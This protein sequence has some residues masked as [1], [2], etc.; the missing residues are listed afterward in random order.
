LPTPRDFGALA[1]TTS[2]HESQTSLPL[3]QLENRMKTVSPKRANGAPPPLANHSNQRHRL[4]TLSAFA[5]IMNLAANQ[6]VAAQADGTLLVLAIRK[7]TNVTEMWCSTTTTTPPT[8][9]PP[10]SDYVL[11]TRDSD[12]Q[13]W[14]R[15]SIAV[16]NIPLEDPNA[17]PPGLATVNVT[18]FP[19]R[20]TTWEEAHTVACKP[21]RP[22]TG[23]TVSVDA[24]QSLWFAYAHPAYPVRRWLEIGDTY[25][26]LAIPVP[27]LATKVALSVNVS[28]LWGHVNGDFSQAS[29]QGSDV[30][31]DP[32]YQDNYREM[33]LQ[34][35]N[36]WNITGIS[37]KLNMFVIMF[38]GDASLT[39]TNYNTEIAVGLSTTSIDIPTSPVPTKLYLAMHDGYEWTNNN[40]IVD[41]G[42]TWMK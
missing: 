3:N 16:P 28:E 4:R 40:G 32:R 30:P 20:S 42:I 21:Y 17:L 36:S 11:M 38:G 6:P 31:L 39:G 12:D 5:E 18:V 1:A 29:G 10:S 37:T 9:S 8:T 33:N 15:V 24:R 26:P 23:S 35:L 2:M 14:F 25:R 22:T 19:L 13:N 41:V 27:A 34:G 7:Q